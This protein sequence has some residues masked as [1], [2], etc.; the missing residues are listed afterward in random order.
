MEYNVTIIICALRDFLLACSNKFSCGF[1]RVIAH[2]LW[3][4]WI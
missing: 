2:V 3:N 4:K 1:R